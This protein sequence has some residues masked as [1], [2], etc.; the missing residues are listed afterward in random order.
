MSEILDKGK[1]IDAGKMLDWIDD[2]TKG[3]LPMGAH[4]FGIKQGLNKLKLK[5]ESGYFNP[6]PTLDVP[7]V[8]PGDTFNYTGWQFPFLDGSKIDHLRIHTFGIYAVVIY[9]CENYTIPI[10]HCKPIR[11]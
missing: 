11:N 9:E 10:Y 8:N 3:V 7:E 4:G 6:D 2:I 1:L 5:I